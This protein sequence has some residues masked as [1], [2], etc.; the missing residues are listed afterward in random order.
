MNPRFSP[1]CQWLCVP[2]QKLSG[3]LRAAAQLIEQVLVVQSNMCNLKAKLRPERCPE[4][5]VLDYY[6]LGVAVIFL[7]AGNFKFEMY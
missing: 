6:K 1:G 5:M 3:C 4:A 2:S 7:R